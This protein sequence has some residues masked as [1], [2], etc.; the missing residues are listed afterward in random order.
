MV[1]RLI[2]LTMMLLCIFVMGAQEVQQLPLNPKVRHGKLANGLN[3]YV[4]HNEEPKDR[5]NFYIAQKVGSTLETPEQLGL[6]HFLE[7]MAFN[8]T[9]NFPGKSMLEYL[10]HK[11]IRF[12]ADINAYTSFDETVYNIDNVPT[13][14]QA[15]MDS[16]LLVLH[17]WSCDLLLEDAEIDA[18]RGVIQGEARQRNDANNRM[19]TTILPLV[20]KEY[21]YHQMPIGSMEVVKNFPYKALRDYYH[22]WYRPDQQG[23]VVVG[24]FDV[25]AMEKKIVELFTPIVMPENAAP[26]T[27]P[28][29]SDNVEPIYAA[30]EDP[31]LQQHMVMFMIKSDTT[32]FE[33]RNTP[34]YYI[35]TSV[36][37]PLIQLMMSE[38][39][40]ELQKSPECTFTNAGLSFDN[41]MIAKTKDALD[42]TVYAKD[43][44][45]AAF[46]EVY[47]AVVRAFRTG[48]T[49]SELERAKDKLKAMYERAYNE[50]DKTNT[51]ALAKEIIRTYIDNEPNPGI[52][53][54]WQLIQMILPQ[55]TVDQINPV[56]NQ[57]ITKENQVMVVA[58]PKAEGKTLPTKEEMF[59]IVSNVEGAQYE[60]YVDD[61]LDEPILAKLPKKG[62]IKSTKEIP[63]FGA[64]EF[65]LSN[66]AHV[67]LKTTDF[68]SDE[69]MFSAVLPFGKMSMNAADATE[70]KV[71]PLAV[72]VS[73]L[74]NFSNT[75]L[76]KALAGKRV[77]SSFMLDNYTAGFSGKSSVKDLETLMQ[78][79]YL[80][81]TN[82]QPDSEM[83]AATV[84]QYA[85]M[86]ANNEKNPNFVFAKEYQK[87]LYNN[88]PMLTQLTS[89]DITSA[90]Y[91]KMLSIAKQYL[92]NAADYDFIF[93]GNIDAQTLKPL[94][95]QYIAALPGN[96]KKTAKLANEL[97][98]L[99]PGKVDNKFEQEVE[100]DIVK[101]F[102][103]ISG[104]NL[105]YSLENDA[106]MSLMGE[107]L[108]MIYIR[109]LRE[110]LGGTY[111]ASVMGSISPRT[112]QW[113]L[114]YVYD[115]NDAQRQALDDRAV[116]DLTDLMKNGA[117]ADDFN[118]VK[119][120]ELTQSDLNKKKNGYWMSRL[121][122]YATMG[123]DVTA[124]RDAVAKITLEDL[125]AFM[126]KLYDGKNRIHVVMDGVMPAKPAE[127]A[128]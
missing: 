61:V 98:K 38:R 127:A 100:S 65:T 95:E 54:E 68:A 64:T 67:Y 2:G 41:F 42:V 20:F 85:A 8:G 58:Q 27:Y 7:H 74:G 121:T 56:L 125:N 31:E 36:I 33:L 26:R 124:Y 22:K 79:L 101:E 18:E 99:T 82:I 111:G 9:K 63:A 71:L 47:S 112:N 106:M 77:S 123:L 117:S 55:L 52:E 39:F 17:D 59:A 49:A 92:Q 102:V 109:T 97:I 120:A 3:Y 113:T 116:S 93:V 28:T 119:E 118:K 29:V 4:M 72:E 57:F 13:N 12:G 19:F 73:K 91:N 34:D 94:L 128:K 45:K 23:I 114:L 48:F 53:A 88:N 83:Y 69:I 105:Q 1:K 110:E 10:Q 25:D 5:A 75:Q 32:P 70:A 40:D 66:G 87:S 11:G 126:K 90:D 81:F 84:G 50:R 14:D 24:D 37:Q 6:A 103:A 21:Q 80:Q 30:F 16:V 46:N 44:V 60:A 76:S 78:I 89:A 107:I 51:A 96:P 35:A 15:L 86:L 108:N 115:T 62:K 43:D 104:D 122:E